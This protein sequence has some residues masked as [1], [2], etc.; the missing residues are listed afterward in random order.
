MK[1]PASWLQTEF[2]AALPSPE[3]IAEAF[4]FHAFEID[5]I[6]GDV[7]DVKVLPNRAAD[8]LS[9]RGLAKELSAILD[10]PMKEDVLRRP[11]PAFPPTDALKVEVDPL[12]VL[13]HTGAL[14]TGVAVGPSPAWLKELLESMGQRSINNIVD[15]TN[16]VMLSLGQPM[17]AFDAGKIA[18]GSGGLHITIRPAK[19]GEK[20]TILSGEEHALSQSMYVIADA[21]SGLALDIAGIKGGLASGID[22]NT[23]DIFISVGNYDGTLIRR[24]S[25]KLKIFTDASQRYQNRPSPELTAYGMQAIL[26][27]IKDVAGGE[28]VGV[29]DAYPKKPGALLPIT[30]SLERLN[31]ILGADFKEDEVMDVFRRLDLPASLS[32][33][34]FVVSPPFERTD[35]TLP[36]D[37]AEEAGRIL[38]YERVIP[39]E[40]E[41][42]GAVDQAR[43]RGMERVKDFLLER[44][45]TEVSTQSFAAKGEVKLANP[46]DK[47]K[48]AL[49]T[50]LSENLK[51]ALVKAKL[52]AP[53]TLPPNAKPKLFELGTVFSKDGE[54]VVVETSEPVPDIPP[55]VGDA[56][57]EPRRYM[58][59]PYKPFSLYPFIVRDVAL[60]VPEGTDAADIASVIRA[61]VGTLLVRLQQFDTFS[62][63]GRTSYAFRLVFQADDRTLTDEE[64]A[65]WME[66]VTEA[67]TKRGWEVR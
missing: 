28:L 58:L 13:R 39:R 38:G 37:I 17:H 9:K 20:V 24:A 34:T 48:P 43:F 51:E 2:E 40:L 36:E 15:A 49:R 18:G 10:I 30:V 33:G 50:T 5:S 47:T 35:L 66:A 14:V 6:E 4:T 64:A 32:Q 65:G 41:S 19:E 59:S 67:L 46:L 31:Q 44:G 27:V 26:S 61:S 52:Y 12:F 1:I 8:C 57:Y 23:K 55:L 16:Y 45:F 62:K 60:W 54:R 29:V 25:Q 11:A 42:D 56:A 7:L 22:E 3:K 53:I 63:E 21:T